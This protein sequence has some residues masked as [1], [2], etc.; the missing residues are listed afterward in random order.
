MHGRGRA[1]EWLT[2]T[3]PIGSSIVEAAERFTSAAGRADV[4]SPETRSPMTPESGSQVSEIT[5]I[6]KAVC[7]YD[8]FCLHNYECKCGWEFRNNAPYPGPDAA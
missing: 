7:G 1:L 8:G 2:H 3:N 5:P 4:L 6:R